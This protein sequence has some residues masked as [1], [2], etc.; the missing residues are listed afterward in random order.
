MALRKF[1]IKLV[2]IFLLILFFAPQIIAQESFSLDKKSF[3]WEIKSDTAIV[4][5]LGSI[6]VANESFY[7]LNE[8]IENAFN[9][10]SALVVE[11]NPLTLDMK[12]M[13]GIILERGFYKG[14]ETIQNNITEDTFNLLSSFF[15]KNS[16]PLQSFLKMKPTIL[17]VTLTT[18]KLAK[19]GY[20][21]EYGIDKYFCQ[22]AK[23]GKPIIELEKMEEQL[24]LL[25]DIP[26]ENSLLKY[27]LIELEKMEELFTGIIESWNRGDHKAIDNI[28]LKPY[29]KSSEFKPF[30]EKMFYERNIKMVSKIKD[31]LRE[32]Q[33]FFV[34]VGAGHLVGKKGIIQL[35]QSENYSIK[36][37]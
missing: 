30:L 7:P 24:S 2:F 14:D 22:K 1:F 6:H 35:M 11:L 4:F 5:I 17:G 13:E 10:S 16:I 37:L 28:M 27:T 3:L 15:T 12:K 31:L 8:T 9:S 34:V 18:I 19:M 20:T 21:S 23:E 33:K 26:N 36:Q 29:E 32:N 25:F